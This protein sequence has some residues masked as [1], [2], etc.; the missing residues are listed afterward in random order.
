MERNGVAR[1]FCSGNFNESFLLVCT[2]TK[3][4]DRSNEIPKRDLASNFKR[5]E[6]PV[7]M[8][9]LATNVCRKSRLPFPYRGRS[10]LT[11]DSYHDSPF[12]S[13][14]RRCLAVTLRQEF[15]YLLLPPFYTLFSISVRFVKGLECK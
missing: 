3:I 12:S 9:F 15:S 4:K 13:I 7:S 2:S 6:A 14:H 10:P 8:K 1:I 11:L 5:G